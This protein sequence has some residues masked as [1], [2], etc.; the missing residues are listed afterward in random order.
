MLDVEIGNKGAPNARDATG[1][2]RRLRLRGFIARA[3]A[4]GA[5]PRL[6]IRATAKIAGSNP[7]KRR[8][9]PDLPQLRPNLNCEKRTQI[10]KNARKYSPGLHLQHFYCARY[11]VPSTWAKIVPG[12]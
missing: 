12:G 9:R 8:W 7:I 4:I 1:A 10:R 5:R 3:G 11:E 6:T 2:I